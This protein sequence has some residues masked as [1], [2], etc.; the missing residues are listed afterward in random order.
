MKNKF[1]T[2]IK[3]IIDLD[4]EYTIDLFTLKNECESKWSINIL[5]EN[6]GNNLNYT[7]AVKEK[8]KFVKKY[9]N[10]YEIYKFTS[11]TY[12]M[13]NIITDNL[14]SGIIKFKNL[15]NILDIEY[16]WHDEICSFFLCK[17]FIFEYI[18][19]NYKGVIL[20]GSHTVM[21]KSY[22]IEMMEKILNVYDIYAIY[23]DINYKIDNQIQLN[24]YYIETGKKYKFLITK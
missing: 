3:D 21:G 7:V 17:E 6:I 13:Y 4:Q 14:T 9:D 8:C 1:V 5:N 22:F 20:D 18:L 11:S 10:I 12:E 16:I 2:C 15:N 23:D 24:R 19:K